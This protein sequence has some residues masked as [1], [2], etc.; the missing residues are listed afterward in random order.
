MYLAFGQDSSCLCEVAVI[1][2][3]GQCR[4]AQPAE[5]PPNTT[6]E[7]L[8]SPRRAAVVRWRKFFHDEPPRLRLARCPEQARTAGR[9]VTVNTASRSLQFPS[10]AC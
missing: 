9:L 1:L 10:Y 3:I 6:D 5:N 8:P 4:E 7:N 2:S